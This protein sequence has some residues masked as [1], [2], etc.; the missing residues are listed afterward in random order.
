MSKNLK[1]FF[2][3]FII[4]LFGWFGADLLH[5]NLLDFFYWR[6]FAQKPEMF[7][8]QINIAAKAG[9]PL[10]Q[11]EE[12][13]E[14]DFVEAE[15][16]MAVLIDGQGEKVLFRKNASESR[17]IA[18]LTKLM[19]AV[20]AIEFY[21][22][23]QIFRISR[24]AVEQEEERG[25]LKVGESLSLEELLHVMLIESSNDAAW[26]VAEGRIAGEEEFLDTEMFVVLMN[27]KNNELGLENTHFVNPTGLDG[28]ENYSTAEDLVGLA[29]YIIEEHPQ[30]LEITQKDSHE[31][32][33]PDGNLHHSITE[34]T[35][36]LLGEIPEIVGGKTGYTEE[37]G[38]CIL[39]ILE[40]EEGDYLIALVL[41]AS[42]PEARFE[43]V[44]KL[45][46]FVKEEYEFS[47]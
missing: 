45:I 31:V 18:S 2:I 46:D 8:A 25:G 41:G 5:E 30:I 6:E 9:K 39:L 3:V 37:A 1:V 34:N 26:A 17:P 7:S 35:N 44:K 24:E 38:G 4:S 13:L 10:F 22:E 12:K 43:E 11:P 27:L 23:E 29:Q 20:A 42:S 36:K 33:T 32:L 14:D 15:S 19:T 28:E 47:I 16:A 21:S 40:N